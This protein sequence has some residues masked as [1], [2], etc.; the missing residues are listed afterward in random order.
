MKLEQDRIDDLNLELTITVAPEDY[1]DNRKKRLN[2]YRKKADFKGFASTSP[3]YPCLSSLSFTLQGCDS[4]QTS[5][6][7]LRC[8]NWFS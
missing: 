2:D 3:L 5:A 4:T 7:P 6:L 8:K 1:E